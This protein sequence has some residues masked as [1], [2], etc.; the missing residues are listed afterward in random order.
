MSKVLDVMGPRIQLVTDLIEN[1]DYSLMKAE[2]PAGVIV[3]VH[4]HDDRETFVVLTGELEAFTEDSWK[5]VKAGETVDIPGDVKHAWRNSSNETVTLLVVSTV[6]MGE[7]FNEIG[8]PVDTVP[9]GPPSLEVLQHF[10]E[11]AIAYGYWLGTP[12]DNASI[13]IKLG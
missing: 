7:F 3:P 8:R 6:K 2:V 1:K 4:S 11:V 5:T 10:V 13:G 9:P 12:E